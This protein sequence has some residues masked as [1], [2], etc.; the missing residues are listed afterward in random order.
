MSVPTYVH[1]QKLWGC[2]SSLEGLS[3]I[4]QRLGQNV[5]KLKEEFNDGSQCET[6]NQ[7]PLVNP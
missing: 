2:M 6:P 7:T 4:V 1:A 3:P 5:A